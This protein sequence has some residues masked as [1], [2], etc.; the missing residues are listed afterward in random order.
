MSWKKIP[1]HPG[2]KL[3]KMHHFTYMMKGVTFLL[4]IDEFSDATFT[5]HGHHS[6]DR[7][8]V[9]ESVSGKSIDDCLTHLIARIG[10]RSGL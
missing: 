4:E 3:F 10:Q 9:V 8:N 2:G 6:T 5:G 7:N 1:V